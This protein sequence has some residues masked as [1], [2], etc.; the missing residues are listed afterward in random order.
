MPISAL[1]LDYRPK[2]I[3]QIFKDFE[4]A[5]SK[6]GERCWFDQKTQTYKSKEFDLMQELGKK[7][8]ERE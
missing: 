5:L 2:K 1:G 7:V 4:Q 3:K 8:S 6:H